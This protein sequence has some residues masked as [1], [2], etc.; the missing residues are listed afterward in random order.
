MSIL[1]S[2]ILVGGGGSGGGGG[3]LPEAPTDG[4]IYGRKNAAWAAVETA[5]YRHIQSTPATN[6]SVQHNLG[7]KP[8]AV[9]TYDD[10]GDEIFGDPLFATATVNWLEIRFSQP[11]SGTA[12]IHTLF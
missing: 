11:V 8:V 12:F 4:K 1:S 6:W 10:N 5:R 3:G 2:G 9:W 7:S